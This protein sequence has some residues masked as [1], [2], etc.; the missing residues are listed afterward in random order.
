MH[1]EMGA[2]IFPCPRKYTSE[3]KIFAR[4]SGFIAHLKTRPETRMHPIVYCWSKF[5]ASHHSRV[6]E[7]RFI[8]ICDTQINRVSL[9]FTWLISPMVMLATPN[10]V[11]CTAMLIAVTIERLFRVAVATLQQDSWQ[12]YPQI[13]SNCHPHKLSVSTCCNRLSPTSATTLM[14]I[15]SKPTILIYVQSG[16]A[17]QSAR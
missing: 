15:Q 3:S 14:P 16:I 7:V 6:L 17:G 11:T 12:S 10:S 8:R 9:T 2:E 5:I 1:S 13:A 4:V